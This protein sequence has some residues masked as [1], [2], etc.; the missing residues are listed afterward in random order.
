MAPNW[1]ASFY[2]LICTGFDPRLVIAATSATLLPRARAESNFFSSIPG[3]SG[4]SVCAF[5]EFARLA[6]PGAPR[7]ANQQGAVGCTL[8]WSWLPL[9][10][11]VVPPPFTGPCMLCSGHQSSGMC[12]TLQKLCILLNC[13][14]TAVALL[15]G[16]QLPGARELVYSSAPLAEDHLVVHCPAAE[17][18]RDLLRPGDSAFSTLA[19]TPTSASSSERT[20]SVSC[21]IREACR[22]SGYSRAEKRTGGRISRYSPSLGCVRFLNVPTASRWGSFKRSS[23]EFTRMAGICAPAR[24]VSHS[25]VVLA[26]MMSTAS[27]YMSDMFCKRSSGVASRASSNNSDRPATSKNLIHR[28]SI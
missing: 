26:G 6:R 22:G 23:T 13:Q 14:Q 16:E 7:C 28:V 25:A 18:Y 10:S 3:D 11:C 1:P 5:P 4:P 21:P 17:A 12:G 27:S 24:R 15:T 8:V 20:S 9:S 19:R 2:H